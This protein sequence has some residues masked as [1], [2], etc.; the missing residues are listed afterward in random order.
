MQAFEAA[1]ALVPLST[2]AA[3]ARADGADRAGEEGSHRAR[4][5]SCR[6]SSRPISTTSRRPRELATQMRQANDR[7]RRQGSA[8]QRADRRDRSVRRRG[9]RD[10]RPPGDGAQRLRRRRRAT[11]RWRS[12]SIRWIAPPR[13]PTSPRA[14]SS[15]ASGRRQEADAG[16][17]RDRAELRARAGAAA[18]A[19]GGRREA[20]RRGALALD[21]VPPGRTSALIARLLA[22]SLAARADRRCRRLHAQLPA[23]RTIGFAGLQW[24]FVRIKY[25]YVTEG[26]RDP[27][28]VLPA[29]RGSSTARPPS[30]TCRGASRPRPPSRSRIRSSWRSTTRGC[31][32]TRGST[33]SSRAPCG[34]STRDVP[35]LREFLLRGGTAMFDDFHGP[36]EWDNFAARD[37]AGVSGSRDRRGAEG[38]SGLHAA[39]TRSTAIPQV[40]GIGSFLSGPHLGEGRLRRRICARF[41]TTPAGR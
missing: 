27:A 4:S 7:R 2:G 36:I 8:R 18:G 26:T 31:S 34:C 22:A 20:M 5:P 41:S 16:G 32:S 9:A 23:A 13:T 11:S 30:R 1:A 25:H 21:A 24:R 33:S 35:I 38:S 17:A 6:R 10:A 29:S 40:A 15:P 3:P 19:G 14:T 28:G 39:S 37:E 12:R